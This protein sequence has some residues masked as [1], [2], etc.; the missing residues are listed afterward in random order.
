M[1]NVYC[2]LLVVL[3]FV[4]GCKD[5]KTVAQVREGG[6]VVVD[7]HAVE[8]ASLISHLNQNRNRGAH[9]AYI[10]AEREV[11]VDGFGRL[12]W[13]VGAS[14]FGTNIWLQTKSGE[15]HIWSGLV[16]SGDVPVYDQ[17]RTL[18][19]IDITAQ[20]VQVAPRCY[21]K[22]AFGIDS[23]VKMLIAGADRVAPPFAIICTE[24]S[25]RCGELLDLFDSLKKYDCKDCV[26]L[27][28]DQLPE[29][30]ENS[31]FISSSGTQWRGFPLSNEQ[32]LKMAYVGLTCL[33]S[34]I[35]ND[36]N[37]PVPLAISESA[38]FSDF[39]N[40]ISSLAKIGGR[41]CQVEVGTENPITLI[42][43]A[44]FAK[45]KES[46]GIDPIDVCINEGQIVIEK[47]A[48]IVESADCTGRGMADELARLVVS[49][50]FICIHTKRSANMELGWLKAFLKECVDLGVTCLTYDIATED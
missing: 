38:R 20:G 47:A 4:L 15:M 34:G 10:S 31:C 23:F 19:S 33:R 2:L 3:L 8:R 13:D 39:Y 32:Y 7:G 5:D 24:G 18:L 48:T 12:L 44:D 22:D 49:K 9:S 35:V 21:S 11:T 50:P 14:S 45:A 6:I 30:E 27:C 26:L 25:A 16:P 1:N 41:C 29:G 42:Y 46:G 36:D 28:F 17:V 40:A 43:D 37:H